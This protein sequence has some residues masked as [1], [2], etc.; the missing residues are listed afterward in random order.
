MNSPKAHESITYRPAQLRMLFR[1]TPFDTNTESGRSRERYRRVALTTVTSTTARGLGTLATFVTVPLAIGYLGKERYGLWMTMTSMVVM[2]AFA[3]FGI[4]NGLLNA[5]SEAHGKRDRESARTFVSSAFFLLTGVALLLALAFAC[6]YPWI[7]WPVL[8]NVKS[9]LACQESAPAMLA[10][11]VCFIVSIP[12]GIV[13]R[14]QL[15]FQEG[16]ANDLWQVAGSLVA[17]GAMLTGMHLRWGLP[18]LI[19]AVAAAPVAAT[20]LNGARLFGRTRRWLAPR[21]DQFQWSAARALGRTGF[22]FF[23]IQITNIVCFCSDNLIVAQML[24]AAAVPQYSV[25]QRAFVLVAIVQSTWLAPLWPAY[26]EAIHRGDT[27]WVRRTVL[28][29]L[30][31]ALAVG[32]GLSL[33]LAA[34]S[35]PLFRFWVGPD[36]VPS[37]PLTIGF[38]MW[39]V[40]QTVGAAVA[41]YLNGSNALVFELSLGVCMLIVVTP[42]K[43]FLCRHI[44]MPGV[45][46]GTLIAYLITTAL[47][48]AIMLPKLLRKMPQGVPVP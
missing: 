27:A 11:V 26:S 9:E 2:L 44:G 12:L 24:G 48:M 17:L 43:I 18:P 41:M 34:I 39:A 25:V 13:Q 4:G 8:F 22:L 28:R 20:F 21:L 1:W 29:S 40:V 15:G 35:R 32:G 30:A 46:G 5:I 23:L 19:L 37:W 14:I 47:P 7:H 31:A 3:D 38:A 45:I 6:F 33:L 10:L 42:L 36:L 16:F